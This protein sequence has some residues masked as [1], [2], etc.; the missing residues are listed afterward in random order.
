[1][2]NKT[3]LIVEDDDSL[4]EIYSLLL[5]LEGHRILKAENGKVAFDLLKSLPHSLLPDCITLDLRMPLMDGN[6]LLKAMSGDSELCRI[7]VILCSAFG[8]YDQTSQIVEV[9]PKPFK[10]EKFLEAIN[11]ILVPSHH[12]QSMTSLP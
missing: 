11:R 10:L 9:F 5:E 12:Y 8:D 1:M 4:R 7:P 6:A 3:I 2:K